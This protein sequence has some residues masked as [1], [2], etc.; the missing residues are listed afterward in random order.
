MGYAFSAVTDDVAALYWN[1]AGIAVPRR[2][3]VLISDV[4]WLAD[5]RN[6]FLGFIMPLGERHSTVGVSL[7]ALTM[8]EEEI[9]ITDKN[10]SYGTYLNDQKLEGE[11]AAILKNNDI[12]RIGCNV[13]IYARTKEGDQLHRNLK[14]FT[15]KT[16]YDI[17]VLDPDKL[18]ERSTYHNLKLPE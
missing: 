15:E 14:Y 11:K 18:Q 10:S 2:T 6:N 9:T 4:E 13:F 7:T 8:G 12:I 17:T 5:T 1:P 16:A 3:E